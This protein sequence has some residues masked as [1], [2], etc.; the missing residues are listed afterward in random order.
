MSLVETL[1]SASGICNESIA[2]VSQVLGIADLSVSGFWPRLKLE[3]SKPKNA[4]PKPKQSLFINRRRLSAVCLC[5]P[6][7]SS[8]SRCSYVGIQITPITGCLSSSKLTQNNNPFKGL[9]DEV[10]PFRELAFSPT[11]APPEDRLAL[12]DAPGCNTRPAPLQPTQEPQ[13]AESA[14]RVWVMMG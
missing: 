4:N 11:L 14:D 5:F 13:T 1:G 3:T 7:F 10:R 6:G 2:S 9:I 12:R 8:I